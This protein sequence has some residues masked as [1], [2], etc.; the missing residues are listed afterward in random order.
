M[1]FQ[2]VEARIVCPLEASR[3]RACVRAWKVP[4]NSNINRNLPGEIIGYW[5]LSRG[6]RKYYR[7]LNTL[8]TS[9]KIRT[10]YKDV[11]DVWIYP[12]KSTISKEGE[13][14]SS[15]QIHRTK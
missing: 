14:E 9:H 12:Q 8:F 15:E 2:E 10:N 4:S 6:R 7:R 5:E 13:G 1:G 3:V 11:F